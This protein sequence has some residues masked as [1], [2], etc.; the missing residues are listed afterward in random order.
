MIECAAAA[1]TRTVM[2][3]ASR[4]ARTL[5]ATATRLRPTVCP[6]VARRGRT[7]LALAALGA[8]L[9]AACLP[10]AQTLQ[11]A[12]LLDELTAARAGFVAATPEQAQSAC[13]IVGNVQTRLY[14]EPGLTS[15]QPTWSQL[16]AAAEAL[17]A[18][19][20]QTTLLA[21]ASGDSPALSAGR[22]RWQVGVQRELGVACDYLRT[23][24]ESLGRP[25]PC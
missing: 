14:G 1:P 6:P 17:Q 20:G 19:C 9:A 25:R 22:Q 8:M 13:D 21:A 4:L 16:R 7:L 15:V 2:E 24:A 5:L 3:R 18:V 12:T 23:A 11:S 10:N